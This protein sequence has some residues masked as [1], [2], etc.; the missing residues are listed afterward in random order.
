MNKITK[1]QKYAVYTLIRLQGVIIESRRKLTLQIIKIRNN[2]EVTA[3]IQTFIIKIVN[4]IY[5]MCQNSIQKKITD[6]I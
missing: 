6:F 4:K 2:L 1:R 5:G 3:I